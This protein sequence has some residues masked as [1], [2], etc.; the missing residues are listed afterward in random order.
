MEFNQP[1]HSH[2]VFSIIT[3]SC[4]RPELLKRSIRSVINQ[5]FTD[6]EHIIV[7]DAGDLDITALN[8]EFSDKR[9]IFIRNNRL[10]GAAGA[11]NSGIIKSRGEFILFLDDDDEY[12]PDFLEKM[13]LLFAESENNPG[14]AW[15]GISRIKDTPDGETEE[16]SLI[17]PSCFKDKEKGLIEATSIGNGFGVC[18]RRDC[19]EETGLYDETLKVGA[20]T[21]FLFRLAIN[22][23][24]CTIPETL[25][26]IHQHSV[27][28]LTG[29]ENNPERLR[30]WE[31]I[32]GRYNDFLQQYP[33]V[34]ITHYNSF[35]NLCY[36]L[37]AKKKGRRILSSIMKKKP[38]RI[39]T[40]VDFISYE[41]T[42]C[43]ASGSYFGKIIL[44]FKYLN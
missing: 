18:V 21:D 34:Y 9:L 15:S 5:T 39:K 24:F 36:K 33:G 28:Q 1:N 3:P 23:N 13:N 31:I 35:A 11:Y 4:R 6:Y 38:L 2:P 37:K 16:F 12:K 14:F 42:G 20:D 30:M 27:N 8:D 26:K 40:Y 22:Y 7:D 29:R 19:I 41:L 10:K 44:R 17:W 43:N 25:V 32:L